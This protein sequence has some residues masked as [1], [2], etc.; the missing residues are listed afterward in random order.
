MTSM[1]AFAEAERQDNLARQCGVHDPAFH[2]LVRDRDWWLNEA[3][4][5]E[6][7][8]TAGDTVAK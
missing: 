7:I 1:E 2:F 6:K 4:R 5:L 8:E 3:V